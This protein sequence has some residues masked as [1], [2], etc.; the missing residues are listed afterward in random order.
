MI[1]QNHF[2]L[3]VYMFLKQ[4]LRIV[5]LKDKGKMTFTIH[6]LNYAVDHHQIKLIFGVLER[7]LQIFF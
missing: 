6:C 2:K 7:V 4:I 3:V 1:K 5:T